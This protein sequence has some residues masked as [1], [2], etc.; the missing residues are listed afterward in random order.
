MS[1]VSLEL[2][3]KLKEAGLRWEPKI[4]DLYYSPD[5]PNGWENI[6]I[7]VLHENYELLK[8]EQKEKGILWAPRLD[9]LLAEIEAQRY[10]WSLHYIADFNRYHVF[11]KILKNNLPMEDFLR[12][13]YDVYADTPE[14]TTGQAL[15][16]ILERG[17]ERD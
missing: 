12:I 9:Q 6:P 7:R 4:C 14:D 8:Q 13:D 5:A 2:A 15:L 10:Q 16:W 11:L 17:R 1:H 3:R